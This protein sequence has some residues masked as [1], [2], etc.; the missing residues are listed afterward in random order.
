MD[1]MQQMF[2]ARIKSGPIFQAQLVKSWF[3]FVWTWVQADVV[4]F[5]ILKIFQ[6][7]YSTCLN[8]NIHVSRDCP[9]LS[10][11][12]W[13]Y[14]DR[15]NTFQSGYVLSEVKLPPWD[16]EWLFSVLN[17]FNFNNT[18]KLP[19]LLGACR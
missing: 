8:E 1:D 16:F 2:T 18:R 10:V 5:N 3:V 13:L 6:I 14:S 17:A 9:F 15:H 11:T 19:V 12:L 4:F 7:N